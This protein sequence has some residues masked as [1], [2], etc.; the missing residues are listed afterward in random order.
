MFKH[1][2]RCSNTLC[3]T[4][5]ASIGFRAIVTTMCDYYPIEYHYS[6]KNKEWWVY[7][8]Q[9]QQP[10]HGK[11]GSLP[12]F[13][14]VGC[15]TDVARRLRQHNGEI[16]GGAKYTSQ[17]RPW[18][19]KTFY[20]PYYGQSEALKAERALKHGKRGEARTRWC[21]SDSIW[22]RLPPFLPCPQGGMVSIDQ[23]TNRD[24]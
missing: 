6:M 12:G 24:S 14:Y 8:I 20:G 7:V 18:V 3:A 22:C 10:R 1:P 19:L 15:T 17:H 4:D 16:A 23:P 21:P 11:R 5:C 9:S 2:A 13:Y